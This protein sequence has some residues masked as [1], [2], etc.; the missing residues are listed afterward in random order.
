MLASIWSAMSRLL[1]TCSWP[2][3]RHR[4]LALP[5]DV[6]RARA[7]DPVDRRQAP[8]GL[9]RPSTNAGRPYR[10]DR[11]MKSS[12]LRPTRPRTCSRLYP[13]SSNA[14]VMLGQSDQSRK[15]SGK[16]PMVGTLLGSN[17]ASMKACRVAG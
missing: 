9:I 10:P 14:A 7:R 12:Q 13:A 1:F 8:V 3:Q 6:G 17:P 16:W 2:F 4:R 11:F 5:S 15:P